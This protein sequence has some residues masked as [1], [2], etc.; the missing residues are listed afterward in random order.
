M[1]SPDNKQFE[2]DPHLSTTHQALRSTQQTFGILLTAITREQQDL[3]ERIVTMSP[4]VAS[5]IN[6]GGWIN[7]QE[8]WSRTPREELPEPIK[9]PVLKWT[10]SPR[11]RHIELGISENNLFM[12]LGQFGLSHEMFGELLFPVGTLYNPF[13]RR[14]LDAFLWPVFR[15]EIYRCGHTV[16]SVACAGR[17]IHQ[18]LLTSSIGMELPEIA[19]YE[20][21]FGQELE[22]IL[23]DALDKVQRRERSTYLRLT[24]RRVDQ[25]HFSQPQDPTARDQL[26]DQVLQGA[27]RLIDARSRPGCQPGR[28]VVHLFA[29][30]C[31]VPEAMIA[32]ESMDTEDIHV[33]LFNVTGPG[34]LYRLMHNAMQ[35]PSDEQNERLGPLGNLVPAKERDAPVVTMIDGHPHSLAWIGGALGTDGWPLGVVAFGQSGNV[36]DIYRKHGIDAENIALTCRKALGTA[37]NFAA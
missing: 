17:R 19:F 11:G 23:L 9:A 32:I 10:E 33:N 2:I 36:P 13:V 27:Y 21:C 1:S 31:L 5:S 24:T 28:N 26:R 15:S 4:D 3:A 30:G 8:V 29:T 22:W 34:P 7:K 14:G 16:R 18:S 20:P 25:Q 12:A 35:A 37:T 6:L